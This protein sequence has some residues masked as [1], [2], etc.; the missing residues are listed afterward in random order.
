MEEIIRQPKPQLKEEIKP[1]VPT[2]EEAEEVKQP[3]NQQPEILKGGE[4]ISISRSEQS[5]T[6]NSAFLSCEG[7]ANLTVAILS[8]PVIKEF[9]NGETKK[10]KDYY[11]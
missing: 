5:I 4:S 9:L 2:G 3:Q 10:P 7:L 1:P 6:L 8:N 11:G